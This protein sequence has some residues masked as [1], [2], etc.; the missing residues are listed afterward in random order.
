MGCTSSSI[1]VVAGEPIRKEVYLK[2]NSKITY[3]D[4]IKEE[5]K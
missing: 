1:D 4:K 3:K 2:E 5:A